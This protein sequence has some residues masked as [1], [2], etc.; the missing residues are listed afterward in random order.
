[1]QISITGNWNNRFFAKTTKGGDIDSSAKTFNHITSSD[2]AYTL[3]EL[4]VVMF[5]IGI[6]LALTMPR[7]QSVFLSDDLKTAT[8]RMIGTVKTLREKAM[9]EQKTIKLY[10]DMESN[11]YWSEWVTMT[12]EDK[13]EA[14]E[15]ASE[16]P[17]NIQI[18]DVARRGKEKKSVGDAVIRFSKKG[19]VEQAV[20][21]LGANQDRVCALVLSPFL[22]TVKVYDEYTDL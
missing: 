13:A 3:I 8:R 15:N 19:Y 17:G 4:T 7:I 22:G 10:L 1:M 14:R 5:L 16:L 6:M 11:R 21:H 20:I 18:I 9:R 2:H 12:D